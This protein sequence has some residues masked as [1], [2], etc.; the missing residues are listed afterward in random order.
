MAAKPAKPHTLPFRPPGDTITQR[1]D[2]ARDFVTGHARIAKRWRQS[3]DG[4]IIAAANAAGFDFHPDLPWTRLRHILFDK[5]QGATLG[6]DLHGPHFLAHS[7][8]RWSE[9]AFD[10]RAG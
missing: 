2:H 5:L 10:R 3:C 1:V 8:L 4:D 7:L 9:L 6:A